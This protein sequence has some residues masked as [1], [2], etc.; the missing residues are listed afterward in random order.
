MT[1]QRKNDFREEETEGHSVV[2]MANTKLNDA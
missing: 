1:K 2:L